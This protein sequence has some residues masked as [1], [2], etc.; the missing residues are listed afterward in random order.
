MVMRPSFQPFGIVVLV[1][2]LID[3]AVLDFRLFYRVLDIIL[4]RLRLKNS[5]CGGGLPV[6]YSSSG[7]AVQRRGA[8]ILSASEGAPLLAIV[9]ALESSQ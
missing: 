9:E 6:L 7:L 2:L 4:D 1:L 3:S 5:R 8:S